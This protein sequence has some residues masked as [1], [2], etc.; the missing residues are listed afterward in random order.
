MKHAAQYH[1]I[2]WG[3][4]RGWGERWEEGGDI[5][6]RW[7]KRS[8]ERSCQGRGREEREGGEEGELWKDRILK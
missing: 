1:L 5:M 2:S 3:R 4:E 7:R 8:L 6:E